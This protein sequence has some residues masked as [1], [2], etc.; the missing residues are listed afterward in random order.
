MIPLCA[1]PGAQVVQAF[2]SDKELRLFREW[3][4]SPG[5]GGAARGC[6]QPRAARRQAQAQGPAGGQRH[7]PRLGPHG[8]SAPPASAMLLMLTE[9]AL[10]SCWG[11]GAGDAEV[12]G[13]GQGDEDEGSA[14]VVKFKLEHRKVRKNWDLPERFPDARVIKAYR[15]VGLTPHYMAALQLRTP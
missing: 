4:M 3:V 14:L 9:A 6:R 1:V 2:R 11:A 7:R 13:A 15:E 8:S 12:H 5:R 10:C